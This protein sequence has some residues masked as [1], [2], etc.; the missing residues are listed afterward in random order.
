MLHGDMLKQFAGCVAA[1][2]ADRHDN[3][4]VQMDIW[5]S[6][7]GRFHQ[8]LVDPNVDLLHA[9]WSPWSPVP[10]LLPLIRHLDWWRPVM[11]DAKRNTDDNLLFFADFPGTYIGPEIWSLFFVFMFFKL[12]SI[13]I[14][15]HKKKESSI[16]NNYNKNTKLFYY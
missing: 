8:R 1:N 3:I 14:T 4:S 15:D 6:L 16:L 12:L 2:M 13:K 7:N 10:W 9:P 11:V 5:G